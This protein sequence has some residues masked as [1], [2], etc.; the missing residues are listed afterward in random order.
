MIFFTLAMMSHVEGIL[1]PRGQQSKFL[2]QDTIGQPYIKMQLNT[3]GNVI[4]VRGWVGLPNLTKC[5]C[6]HK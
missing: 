6:I 2:M 1:L 3:L 5:H 4:G